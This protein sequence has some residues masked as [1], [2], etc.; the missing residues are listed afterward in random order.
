MRS[1]RNSLVLIIAWL[2][3]ACGSTGSSPPDNP[4]LVIYDEVP[5]GSLVITEIQAHPNSGRPEFV[6]FFHSGEEAIDLVG[7]QIVD[8]GNQEHRHSITE[9][10]VVEPGTWL[11]ASASA[12]LGADP[13]D[14]P[15]DIQWSEIEIG[16]SDSSEQ[17]ALNCPDGTGARHTIDRVDIDWAGLGLRQGHSWQLDGPPDAEANDSPDQW[18]EAPTEISVVYA[19]IN[20][21]PDYGTPG[22]ESFCLNLEGVPPTEAGQVVI[23]E[24]LVGQ[25]P[26]LR[27][28]FELHNPTDFDLELE[29]CLLG[30]ASAAEPEQSNVHTLERNIGETV[31]PSGGYLLLAKSGVDLTEDASVLAHY[32]YS[33][34]IF[35]NSGEQLLWLDCPI[36]VGGPM[37]RIDE[38]TYDWDP[39]GTAFQGRSL[40]LDPGAAGAEGNDDPEAWCLASDDSLYWTLEDGKDT[41]EARG[42]PG[43]ANPD[44]PVADPPPAA[45]EVV[46]TEILV[47]SAGAEI[48]HNE[49]WFELLNLADHAVSFEG[50]LIRHENTNGIEDD[51]IDPA[52]PLAVAPGAYAVFVRSSASDTI[53]C[54]LPY[55]HAYGNN[56]SFGND[57]P[58]TLSLVCGSPEESVLV[59]TIS[60][61]GDLEGFQPGFPRQLL[62]TAEDATLNDEAANWCVAAEAASYS[63]SCTVGADSNYGTPGGSSSCQ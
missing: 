13:E 51:P 54:D 22:G 27:E 15:T 31:I 29:G 33:S 50:C 26:G 10:L 36:G 61:N 56:I 40:S 46:F 47:H 21:Q 52:F 59:D 53:A 18:C 42:S 44:C 5:I 55:D 43:T 28:W 60:F 3:V 41:F 45:G 24:L 37:I 30:D 7:C 19:V 23:T 12:S 17:L 14:L 35:N 38:V 63:W 25:F 8:S 9:S 39:F 16:E 4:K 58:Q 32:P 2:L 57:A 6:E 1:L 11:L 49:E 34:L 62:A 48:G 20:G